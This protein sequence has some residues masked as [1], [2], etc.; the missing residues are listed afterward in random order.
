MKYFAF[1]LLMLV[2][3]SG[4]ANQSEIEQKKI[5]ALLEA[6]RASDVT[7]IRNGKEHTSEKAFKHLQRKLKSAQR[8]WF[9][10]PK[11]E[12]TAKL[13]I[14][15]VASGSSLS[16]KPYLVRTKEGKTAEAQLWLLERLKE[17]EGGKAQDI[18]VD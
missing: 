10:P 14:E 1:V 12:W 2:S 16:G 18:S 4:F 7:F 3:W 9:A 8:S 15:K 6:I 17:L 13:F 5:E 11:K